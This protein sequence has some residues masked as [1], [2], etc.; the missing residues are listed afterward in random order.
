[1]NERAER[2]IKR[3]GD[4]ERLLRSHLDLSSNSLKRT[5]DQYVGEN[6]TLSRLLTPG[7]SNQLLSA[8]GDAVKNLV[9][10]QRDQ[11]LFEFSLD[12]ENGAL[13]RLVEETKHSRAI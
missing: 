11:I 9:T 6:S 5:L 2:L 1:L 12:N 4:L 7:E 13:C 8:I 10:A 3:D